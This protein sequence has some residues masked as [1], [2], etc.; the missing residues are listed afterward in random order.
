VNLR[1][2]L[3][4]AALSLALVFGAPGVHAEANH[5][6]KPSSL[7]RHTK[8]LLSEPVAS[9]AK[10]TIVFILDG[11]RPD[12]INPRDTPNLYDLRTRGVF[13]ENGHAVFPTVTR[14]NSPSIAT[15]FYPSAVGIMGNSIYV[16]EI[17]PS[18]DISTGEWRNLTRLD[19]VSGG[20]LLFVQSLAERLHAAGKTL[21][22]VSS[23]SS[24]SAFLL[25]HKAGEG[26]GVLVNRT[27]G[28]ATAPRVAFPD[29]VN[30]EILA[31][32]GAP[33]PR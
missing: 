26:V 32:F 8:Q 1:H 7:Q 16:P 22:A 11:L 21:A 5:A 20:R 6:R 18:N 24:G 30:A 31:R 9:Q 3:T 29:D 23:G 28:T 4:G 12:S 10:L 15:G 33:R 27:L 17:D 14:V 13:F 2:S 19:E 25:N